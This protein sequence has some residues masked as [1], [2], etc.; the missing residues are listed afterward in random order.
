[1]EFSGNIIISGASASPKT[2]NNLIIPSQETKIFADNNV[3][4]IVD[5]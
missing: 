2:I 4:S 3:D 5:T 1:M